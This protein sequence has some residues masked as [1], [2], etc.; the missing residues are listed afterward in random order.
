[1]L[2]RTLRKD[3]T[4]VTFV[5][6]VDNPP[7]PVSVV[8]DFNGWQPGVHMLKARKDGK[9]AVTVELPS[10]TTHSFRYLAAGDYWFNDESAG[11]Q[12]GR[13]SRLHT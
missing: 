12:D 1:M 7:G 11:D 8:G 5:L 13:N 2:E 6:P 9:R 10:E 3:H 4:E